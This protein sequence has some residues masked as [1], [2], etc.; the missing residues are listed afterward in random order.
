MVESN[1]PK[2][3][4]SDNVALLSPSGDVSGAL[5]RAAFVESLADSSIAM[6]YLIPGT[7]YIDQILVMPSS[8]YFGCPSGLA[9][10]MPT[11]TSG[12]GADDRANTVIKIQGT[13]TGTV[14][15]TLSATTY[16]GDGYV[17]STASVG[18]GMASGWLRV[19]G[20]NTAGLSF[21]GDSCTAIISEIVQVASGFSG[22]TT[23]SLNQTVKMHHISGVALQSITPIVDATLEGLF[24]DASSTNTLG[25]AIL[26]ED[27]A[28]ITVKNIQGKNLSRA[29]V[30]VYGSC[31][32]IFDSC[33]NRGSTNCT[34]YRETC[35]YWKAVNSSRTAEG[36]RAHTLGVPR[37]ELSMRAMCVGGL[38]DGGKFTNCSG[39]LRQWGGINNLQCNISAHDIDCTP[40]ISRDP[41]LVDH[42]AVGCVFDG[43]PPSVLPGEGHAEFGFGCGISNV[44]ATNVRGQDPFNPDGGGTVGQWAL[45][46]HDHFDFKASNVSVEN[47][48]RDSA[49]VG[50]YMSGILTSDCSGNF[51]DH[52]I[53]GMRCGLFTANY[54]DQTYW[55]NLIIYSATGELS[56]VDALPIGIYF[57]HQQ[58]YRSSPHFGSIQMVGYLRTWVH[59]GN[60][61]V[62]NALE[63]DFLSLEGRPFCKVK[64]YTSAETVFTVAEGFLGTLTSSSPELVR[65]T[66]PARRN[67]VFAGVPQNGW[68]L[69]AQG[70]STLIYTGSAPATGNILISDSSGN[71]VVSTN[72]PLAAVW[73]QALI[74]GA[75]NYVYAERRS[76]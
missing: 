31:H 4:A 2:L 39:V 30:S 46:Y 19:R 71:A 33:V 50:F 11:F 32:L 8:K 42:Y 53:R 51:S 3:L 20:V 22:G 68:V 14:N 61:F 5:D 70:N 44:Y 52:T 45:Y 58:G 18:I 29:V 75:S 26:I 74:P 12:L 25:S 9:T 38:D 7:Y 63:I 57:A 1:L 24:I 54:I 43:G 76:N 37:P 36:N 62:D 60:T 35:Q 48:G 55:N 40:M 49:Y 73:Y 64:P 34:L 67:V 10:I 66:G 23:V 47:I 16:T 6:V 65:S 15:T 27:C 28:R 56:T 41:D 21:S 69:A 17:K 72:Q 59:F 13:I